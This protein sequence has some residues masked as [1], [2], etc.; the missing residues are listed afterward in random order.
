LTKSKSDV[1][2]Y[3]NG[4]PKPNP[5]VRIKKDIASRR[6]SRV[7]AVV[8]YVGLDAPTVMPLRAGDSLVCD[9]SPTAI[10]SRLTSAQALLEYDKRG[11]AIYSLQGLHAKVICSQSFAWVGSTN[12][13]KNSRD[14]LIEASLRVSGNQ[15]RSVFDWACQQ[16]VED[17]ALSR[18]D[19]RDLKGIPLDPMRRQPRRES[20]AT[21]REIPSG[22]RQIVFYEV[23]PAG[24]REE[25]IAA[26]SRE[27]AK[28][29]ARAKELPSALGYLVWDGPIK[30]EAGGWIIQIS[31]GRVLRPALVVR[32][33]REGQDRTLWLSYVK[34]PKRPTV[35]VLRKVVGEV[36]P[37]FEEYALSGATKVSKV[38]HLFGVR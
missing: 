22:L 21:N 34:T 23:G 6:R 7:V 8:G 38:L 13:S 4:Y 28:A 30:A 17:R 32:V 15:A 35:A 2:G 11:V 33:A 27:A 9:A 19:I 5:W 18:D 14:N 1:V 24:K 36:A 10:K 31:N 26:K 12:A 3:I 20:S 29:T 37:D 25:R 16:I